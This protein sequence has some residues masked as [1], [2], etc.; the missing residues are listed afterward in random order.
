MSSINRFRR[1][2]MESSFA[3]WNLLQAAAPSFRKEPCLERRVSDAYKDWVDSYCNR[4]TTRS[5]STAIAV[6]Y[7]G[8]SVNFLGDGT[9]C[10][11]DGTEFS[12]GRLCLRRRI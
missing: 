4:S 2:V 12:V 5:S 9:M 3:R 10:G 6:S 7:N 8:S 1:G 11:R